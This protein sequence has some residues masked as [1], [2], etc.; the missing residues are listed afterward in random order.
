MDSSSEQE[1]AERQVDDFQQ[2]LGPFV[3]AAQA[4]RMPMVF[5]NA[6]AADHPI[7]FANDSFLALVG[8]HR[9]NVIGQP[10]SF[11]IYG[12]VG[13][14]TLDLVRQQFEHRFETLDVELLRSD[15]SHVWAA[16]CFNPVYDHG[17]EVVQHC[18]S[19]VDLSV[20]MERMRRERAALHVIYEQTPDFIALTEGP[21]HRFT[22]ANV[23]YHNLVGS[24]DLLGR[25]VEEVFPE[26][27]GQ[28]I[29]GHLDNV[30]QTGEPFSGSAMPIRLQR[31]LGADLETRFLDFICQPVREPDGRISG[32]FWEGH[33]VT[34]QRRGAEEI[35]ALQAKLIHLSRVSAMGTMAAT[36]AHELMQPLTAISN[37][38]AAGE[39]RVRIEGGSEAI[40]GDFVAIAQSARRGAEIIRRLRDM[41]MRRRARREIFDLKQAIRES[42]VLVRTGAGAGISIEDRS[43]NGV[44]L[45]ADRIQIQ[46]VLMN[47]IR[48]AC[49]AV[50]AFRGRVRVTTAVHD[51]IVEIS[52]TDSGKGVSARAS[53]TLFT[54]SESSKPQGT[55]MGLSICRTIVEAH[56][57]RLWLGDSR[58]EGARFLFTLPVRR[59]TALVENSASRLVNESSRASPQRG[60]TV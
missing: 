10:F 40:A 38:A 53:K 15:G 28:Q 29:F 19:L 13:S 60:L 32:M 27:R 31:E 24:R 41:S 1:R 39:Y 23:A 42:I 16:L 17:D 54:W 51:G 2:A 52:V 45:E 36:L 14:D 56:G 37:Y 7:I 43:R 18:I 58:G 6:R 20:Q 46:Q 25:S 30:Y 4:T 55:G 50:A 35:E 22:F 48:N 11:L 44:S 57:G 59:G 5:T 9:A 8:H 3:V 49:E 12:A 26:L 47:L 33:D 21:D 34:D